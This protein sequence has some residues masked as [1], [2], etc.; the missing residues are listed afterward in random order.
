MKIRKIF[1]KNLTLMLF[2]IISIA[3][4]GSGRAWGADPGDVVINELMWMGS[5]ASTYDEWIELRNMTSSPINL[6]NWDITKYSSGAETLMLTISSGTI[7]ANGYFLI[8]NY[9]ETS[10]SSKLNVIPDVVDTDVSLANTA[11]QIKLYDGPYAGET[12]TIIDTADDASGTPFA[13]D[14]ANKYSMSRNTTPGDGTVSENWYTATTSLNWDSGATELGTPGAANGSG[15]YVGSIDIDRGIFSSTS[16]TSDITVTDN[17]RNTDSGSKQSF[18]VSIISTTSDPVTISITLTETGNDTGIFNIQ[19]P[20]PELGVSTTASNDANNVIKVADG[21][22]ITATYADA[23]P[24]PSID[25]TDTALYYDGGAPVVINELMWTGSTLSSSD[26]WIELRNTSSS[27]IDLTNW[28]LTKF[29]AGAE[30]P[31]QVTLSGTIKATGDPAGDDYFLISNFDAANSRI[32]DSVTPNVIDTDVV[33]SNSTLQIKLYTDGDILYDTAGDSSTPLAGDNDKKYSMERRSTPGDGTQ[34]KNW[35]TANEEGTTNWDAGAT[36]R[37]S[38][39]ATNTTAPDEGDPGSILINEIATKDTPE[40]IEFHNVSGTTQNIG[41]WRVLERSA[42]IKTFPDYT[43]SDDEY[44]VLRLR[45]DPED[46]T[47]DEVDSDTNG[48]GYRDFYSTDSGLTGTDNV[49]I[50]EDPSGNII[51]AVSLAKRDGTWAGTQRTAFNRIADDSLSPR[52]WIGDAGDEDTYSNETQEG[53]SAN[54]TSGAKGK[55]L[56]RDNASGATDTHKESDWNLIT[57]PTKGKKNPSSLELDVSIKINEVSFN[58]SGS[59]DWVE[60]YC[61]ADGTSDGSGVDIGECYFED[62]GTIKTIAKGTTIKTGEYLVLQ[63]ASGCMT[64]TFID[65]GQGD[66]I[67]VQTPGGE[68]ILIDGG[69]PNKEIVDSYLDKVGVSTTV[70]RMVATHADSDHYGDLTDVLNNKTVEAIWLSGQPESYYTDAFVTAVKNELGYPTISDVNDIPGIVPTV[71]QTYTWDEDYNITAKVLNAHATS[72]WPGATEEEGTDYKNNSSIVIY[73]TYGNV[74]FMLTGDA[75]SSACHDNDPRFEVEENLISKYGIGLTSDI[76]KVGHHGARYATS[77]NFL[78][79]VYPDKAV[80]STGSN[81]YNHPTTECLDRL[82]AKSIPYYCTGTGSRTGAPTGRGNIEIFT[83]GMSYWMD[84]LTAGSDG[85]INIWAHDTGLTSTDEQ[86]IFKD[87]LG[88]IEDA[89]CWADQSGTWGSGEEADVQALVDADPEQWKI[90]GASLAESDCFNSTTVDAN[91][92]IA[93]DADSSDTN[94]NS[95]WSVCSSPTRGKVNNADMPSGVGIRGLGVSEDPFLSDG[96]DLNRRH[97]KISFTLNKESEV[98][99]Q[100][101]DGRGRVVKTL[102]EDKYYI[103]DSFSTKWDGKNSSGDSVPIGYYTIYIK[104]IAEDGNSSTEAT[105]TVTVGKSLSGGG[106][107][108]CFI[109][110]AAYSSCTDR[111]GLKSRIS[112]DKTN[113]LTNFLNCPPEIMALRQF[114][115]QHLLTNP[116]GRAFVLTYCKISPPIADFIRDKEPLK[117]VVRAGLK[118]LVWGANKLIRK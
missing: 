92:S 10:G 97:T 72:P 22:T 19:S 94:A 34:A 86:V 68:N 14:N 99:I 84:E 36:E 43:M 107:G 40:W 112:T 69:N 56:G 9:A 103:A 37:G 52:Q 102:G 18:T 82:S 20:E 55:S 73:L 59:K 5:N 115:D 30:A 76:L 33:L 57:T 75:E 3:L 106:S 89:V 114:R 116:L 8:S 39:K 81:P 77:S 96:S 51:D 88:N 45:D 74:S 79:Y 4:C 105:T 41:S 58:A 100:A 44:I 17:D 50:L 65:V 91:D 47:A 35:Y 32:E 71:G 66:S 29:S 95:D 98:T 117:A 28:Y 54:W 2:L 7:P 24:A 1:S 118:P 110:T 61:E 113:Q 60:L 108:G 104:A 23:E 38:P 16:Q 87:G 101:L 12:T 90:A 62:D 15:N 25:R 70:H 67:L 48:N 13:G 64:V 11:L 78:T 80:I 93:R 31:M 111:H 49:I 21:S 46:P 63:P 109:A 85:I 53:Q 83:N 42:Y 6:S 26:E 27:D